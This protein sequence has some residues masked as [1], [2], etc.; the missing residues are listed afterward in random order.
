MPSNLP[1]GVTES[2][3]PGNRD[4]EMA[5]ETLYRIIG[6]DA[7]KKDMSDQDAFVAWRMGLAAWKASKDLGAKFPH[8]RMEE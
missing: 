4:E 7:M 6:E 1:P 2:M 8:D 3:L 5:W